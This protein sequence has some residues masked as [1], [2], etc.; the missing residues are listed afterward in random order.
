[1]LRNLLC[2]VTSYNWIHIETILNI[3][4]NPQW[5]P[6]DHATHFLGGSDKIARSQYRPWLVDCHINGLYLL[7]AKIDEVIVILQFDT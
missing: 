5:P 1:M 3:S 4:T 2:N 7:N 6:F